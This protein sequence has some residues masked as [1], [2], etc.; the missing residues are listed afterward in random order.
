MKAAMQKQDLEAAV[1]MLAPLA[2][3]RATLPVLSHMRIDCH[4]SV[5]T[6]YATNLEQAAHTEIPAGVGKAGSVLVNAAKLAAIVSSSEVQEIE[7]SADDQASTA[8]IVAGSSTFVLESLQPEEFPAFSAAA[9]DTVPLEGGLLLRILSQVRQAQAADDSRAILCGVNLSIGTGCARAVA[10]DG[11]A[12]AVATAG[13]EGPFPAS[14][15]IPSAAVAELCRILAAVEPARVNVALAE[16]CA[17]FGCGAT[18]LHTRLIGGTYP[19]WSKVVPDGHQNEISID[20]AALLAKARQAA[21]LADS[22]GGSIGL[23]F[24]GNRVAI[25]SQ[26]AEVGRAEGLLR[27]GAGFELSIH[28]APRYLIDALKASGADEA[29]LRLSGPT[30]PVLLV[31]DGLLQV[32]M[33]VRVG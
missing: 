3:P 16:G 14:A 24:A 26:T 28:L 10:T 1:R 23:H 12:L 4:G 6:L 25:R 31:E 21:L 30:D 20:R 13:G 5:A 2:S 19:N 9:A 29:T 11:R 18:T 33:P 22:D 32:I 15:T 7:L 17:T 8:T 27:I